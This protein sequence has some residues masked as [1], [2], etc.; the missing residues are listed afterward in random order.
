MNKEFI[1]RQ[2]GMTLIE[3][4]IYIALVAAVLV[5]ATSFAWNIINSRTKAFA[6]QEVE[7]NGRYIIEKFSQAVRQ[8][9]DITAPVVSASGTD[10]T[11]VMKSAPVNPTILSLSGTRLMF[12]Q[13]AGASVALNSTAVDVTS[14]NFSN[15]SSANGKSKQMRLQFTLETVNPGSRNEW[16]YKNN[17]ETSVELLDR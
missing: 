11:L 17:F 6:V 16:E 4:S 14:L 10:L 1:K 8:A 15:I 13:G 5:M 12:Q 2:D 9:N 3:L 7:Q